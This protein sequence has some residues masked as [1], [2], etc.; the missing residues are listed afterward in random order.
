MLRR[1]TPTLALMTNEEAARLHREHPSRFG[2]FASTSLPNVDAAIAE[3][4][5]ALDGQG[6]DAHKET[7]LLQIRNIPTQALLG[8]RDLPG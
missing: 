1:R 8:H 3:A 5:E 2:W 7:G 6:A 4:G